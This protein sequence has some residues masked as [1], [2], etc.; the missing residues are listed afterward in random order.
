MTVYAPDAAKATGAAVIV[1]PGVGFAFL[2]MKGEGENIARWLSSKGICRVVRNY[3][4]A[5]F[6]TDVPRGKLLKAADRGG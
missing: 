6:A 4:G 1:A 5:R 2:T 3:R